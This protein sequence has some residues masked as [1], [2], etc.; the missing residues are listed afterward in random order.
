ML[1]CITETGDQVTDSPS[2]DLSPTD[3]DNDDQIPQ[4]HDLLSTDKGQ[5]TSSDPIFVDRLNQQPK[6]YSDAGKQ[7]PN[8]YQLHFEKES[9]EEIERRKMVAKKEPI[10]PVEEVKYSNPFKNW[11]VE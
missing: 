7:D 6:R 8:R 11:S 5:S 1:L 3:T 4:S 2:S 10:T 9:K